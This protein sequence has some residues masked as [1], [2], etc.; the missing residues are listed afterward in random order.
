MFCAVPY[1]LWLQRRPDRSTA[2]IVMGGA[3]TAGLAAAVD[4]VAM[5]RPLT[6]GWELALD[7]GG[8][9]GTFVGLAFGLAGG[10]LL[11]RALRQRA[12]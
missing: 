7:R 5:P 12:D 1:S 10:A 6:P 11:A 4:D 8:I 9:S 3:A 2:E